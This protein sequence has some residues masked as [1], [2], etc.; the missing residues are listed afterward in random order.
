[1]MP[2][3]T[4]CTGMLWTDDDGEME[5]VSVDE[6]EWSQCLGAVCGTS[7]HASWT[8][9]VETLSSPSY[10][11]ALSAFCKHT[12]LFASLG[13]GCSYFPPE[14]AFRY[15]PAHGF[16]LSDNVPCAFAPFR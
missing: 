11:P 1:M 8:V 2:Y 13:G 4:L 3:A 16:P 9:I 15:W 14:A 6:A 7:L 10:T 5:P 12:R